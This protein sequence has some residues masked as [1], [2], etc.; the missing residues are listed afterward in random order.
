MNEA[1]TAGT[2]L[3]QLPTLFQQALTPLLVLAGPQLRVELV[4]DAYVQLLHQKSAAGLIGLP[5]RDAIPELAGQGVFEMLEEVYR[6]GRPH[7]G[8][9]ELRMLHDVSGGDALMPAYFD[10]VYQPI[11]AADGSCIGVMAQ[12][13]DVTTY[14][15]ARQHAEERERALTE[16]WQ[17][18]AD[19]YRTSPVGFAM[20]E[21]EEFRMIHV[22]E[23]F[24][25]MLKIP[26]AEMLGKSVLEIA[27]NM[28]GIRQRFQHVADG[29]RLDNVIIEGEL[30]MQPGVFR[31]WLVNYTPLFD[32]HGAVRAISTVSL[33]ITAQKRAETA[34]IKSEKLAA[35]GRLASS[36]A[37]EINNPL[38]SV[39][40]LLYLITQLATDGMQKTYLELADQELRRV[41]V[42]ANQ[43]LR[44]H[45]QLSRPVA[46]GCDNL[47]SSVLSIYEG[48]L[49]NS[50]I[51]LERRIRTDREVLCLDGE[52]RQVLNNLVGNA[53]DAMPNGGRLLLRGRV[54]TD[55]RTGRAG[56]ILTVA[57]TGAGMD[58]KTRNKV[59]EA[60][61]T[62][63]GISGTGLGLW[64]SQE[65]VD[66]HKGRMLLRSSHGQE[67]SGTVLNLFLPFGEEE[68]AAARE[69]D[70]AEVAAL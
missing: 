24:A 18:L 26:A 10:V 56:L 1:L 22:N 45:K 63:K 21:P 6:T 50:R 38:E 7:V 57:D 29:G 28:P 25:E 2:A 41:S 48:R 60:F 55:W 27:G 61:F 66:R 13:T 67:K 46:V 43:T 70:P 4:N 31:T 14:V 68:P 3:L 42:I 49:R 15:M 23:K 9:E 54:G 30:D 59:F 69:L 64:I 36:I 44:F 39:T 37:H 19:M 33:D 51:R 62:T 12:G 34:L 47:F 5:F 11:L 52:M 58:A 20:Y 32:G 8:K 35:V 17:Q 53:V 65:I 40:N 16:E